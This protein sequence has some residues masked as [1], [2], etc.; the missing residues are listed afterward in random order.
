MSRKSFRWVAVAVIALGVAAATVPVLMG[1]QAERT[2]HDQV[3]ALDARLADSREGAGAR[4]VDYER[5]L[6]SA[7]VRTMLELPPSALAPPV[8]ATLGLA[9][10]PVELR[11][12]QSVQ[13]G[14]SSAAFDGY[15]QPVGALAG[16]F[17]RLG[18]TDRS[19]RISGRIGIGR[20]SV[21]VRAESLAGPLD[22]Q[23]QL[24]LRSDPMRF[25][26]V[27]A[28]RDG[29]LTA[30]LL[31]QGVGLDDANNAAELQIDGLQGRTKARRMAGLMDLDFEL[32]WERLYLTDQP[33]LR[34]GLGLEIERLAPAGLE[35]DSRYALALL[36][37]PGP[38]AALT[39]FRMQDDA[40]AGLSA[41]ANLEIKPRMAEL[42]LTGQSGMALWS[43]LHLDAELGIDDALIAAIPAG[44]AD[45]VRQAQAFGILRRQDGQ[46]RLEVSMD[47]GRLSVHGQP[48]WTGG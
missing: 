29:R 36:A 27:H 16:L 21:V 12:T 15:L 20:Q 23:G 43:A 40:G 25:E 3:A 44:Q 13:H 5:G 22:R 1:W 34:G 48:W 42:L 38:R 46:W 33:V 30:E 37:E 17:A 2:W 14:W 28:S 7:R 10:G 39:R 18:G 32:D 35:S 26:A 47:E 6:F 24:Q 11:L 8:R 4:I 41:R 19:L 9:D 31:W 45:W